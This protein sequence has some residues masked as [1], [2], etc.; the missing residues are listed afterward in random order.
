MSNAS[1]P[2]HSE[3]DAL[4]PHAQSVLDE[5]ALPNFALAFD[6]RRARLHAGDMRLLQ[7]ELGRILDG[8]QALLLGDIGGKRVEHGRLAGAGAAGDNGGDARLHGGGE[9]FRHLRL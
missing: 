2:R 4:W 9:Q 7:L 5:L 8:D 6:V 3:D 1:S